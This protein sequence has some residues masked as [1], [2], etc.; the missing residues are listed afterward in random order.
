MPDRFLLPPEMEEALLIVE[1][2]FPP[3]VI[4]NWPQS[5]IDR[6][7]IYKGVRNVA[8]YGGDWQP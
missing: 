4:D 2:G 5:L 1:T 3:E 7:L 6:V 8:K